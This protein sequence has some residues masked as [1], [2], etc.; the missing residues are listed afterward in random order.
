M[1]MKLPVAECLV[2]DRSWPDRDPRPRSAIRPD[3]RS[4]VVL[5]GNLQGIIDLDT[6]VA[7]D[8]LQLGVA[9]Q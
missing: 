3:R 8:A 2:N 9:E 5:L 4:D 1:R 7:D 6:E